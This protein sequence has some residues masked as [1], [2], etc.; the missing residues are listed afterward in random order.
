MWPA[1][2]AVRLRERGHDAIAVLERP[3]LVD[4]SDDAIFAAAQE[5]ERAVFTENVGDYIPLANARLAADTRFHGLVMTSNAAYPR[6]HARTLGRAVSALDE[7]MRARPGQRDG[8][9][10]FDWLAAAS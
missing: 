5:E 2:L 10:R 3:D 6:G 1:T 7:Y 4:Q 9:N 8:V